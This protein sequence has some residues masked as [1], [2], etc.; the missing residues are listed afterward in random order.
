MAPIL[1]H[2]E[3]SGNGGTVALIGLG[4]CL[5][6]TKI[7]EHFLDILNNLKA[8]PNWQPIKKR[9]REEGGTRRKSGLKKT[10]RRS[11]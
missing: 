6:T 1:N 5:D 2:I 7:S 11:I 4:N 8:N 9:R 3:K 10:K